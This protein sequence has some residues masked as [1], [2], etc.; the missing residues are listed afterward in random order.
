LVIIKKPRRKDKISPLPRAMTISMQGHFSLFTVHV[1]RNTWKCPS[2]LVHYYFYSKG[3]IGH[4]T[5][6]IKIKRL[7]YPSSKAICALSIKVIS[8]FH[9]SNPQ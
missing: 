8:T 1:K 4:F 2:P 9:C 5:M 6:K 7:L 3:H